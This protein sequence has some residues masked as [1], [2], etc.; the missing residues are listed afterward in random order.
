M[1]TLYGLGFKCVNIGATRISGIETSIGGNG[2]IGPV[3]ISILGSYTYKS[4][5]FKSK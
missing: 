3:D 2:K 4:Y 5:Y 1:L